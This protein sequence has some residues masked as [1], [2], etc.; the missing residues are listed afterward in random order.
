MPLLPL[1]DSLPLSEQLLLLLEAVDEHLIVGADQVRQD[2][3]L[4]GRGGTS[5]AGAVIITA[6]IV[7]PADPRRSGTRGGEPLPPV[8]ELVTF[9]QSDEQHLVA[10]L[11]GLLDLEHE[12]A[13]LAHVDV[14]LVRVLDAQDALSARVGPHAICLVEVR[15]A[16]AD[17][18]AQLL[19]VKGRAVQVEEVQEETPQVPRYAT[20]VSGAGVRDSCLA[21]HLRDQPV[22]RGG[23]DRKGGKACLEEGHDQDTQ[24]K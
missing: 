11:E 6:A 12:E 8:I 23:R 16:L 2:G 1:L 19:V 10:V 18:D 5:T 4:T 9:E 21:P 20:S 24:H 15:A 3:G 17:G 22:R 13:V 14:G 7:D